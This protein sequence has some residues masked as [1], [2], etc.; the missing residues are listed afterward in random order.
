[1]LIFGGISLINITIND[2][3][4]DEILNEIYSNCTLHEYFNDKLTSPEM[5]LIGEYIANNCGNEVLNELWEY[6]I[7]KHTW[8]YI[9]PII[10]ITLPQQQQQKPNPRYAHSSIYIEI[11][12][13]NFLHKYMYIYGGM[14]LSN[15]EPFA[16]MWR[17]EIAYFPKKYQHNS[18]NKGNI[19]TLLTPPDGVHP[20]PR[21]HHS[22]TAIVQDSVYKY[23]YLF[24]GIRSESEILNDLWLYDL[25]KAT[26]KEIIPRGILNAYRSIMYWNG[27]TTRI[28]IPLEE[29]NF[30]TDYIETVSKAK[31]IGK[32]PAPR[33]SFGFAGVN[34]KGSSYVL[35]YGGFKWEKITNEDESFNFQ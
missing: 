30:A 17:Y 35:L 19:W 15:T 3:N 21:E 18:T 34:I 26:W 11:I 24:G 1:M 25:S 6:N 8:N 9:Q 28:S 32:F 2:G 5:K 27:M 10:D 31:G 4:K 12:E 16:D 13:D 22:M 23:I 7:N 20:G 29:A 33:A 14:S